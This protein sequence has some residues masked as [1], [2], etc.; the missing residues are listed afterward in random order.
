MEFPSL[1]ENVGFARN[2]A[3]VF[4]SRLDFTLDELDDIRMAVSEAVTNAVVPRLRE[5]AGH[6]P[7]H[8][9]SRRRLTGH[10]R[11]GP[12]QGDPRRGVGETARQTPLRPT[13]TWASG[14]TSSA[15]AWTGTSRTRVG[16]GTRIRMVK[17]PAQAKRQ[18]PAAS[19]SSRSMTGRRRRAPG[20]RRSR[21]G[22]STERGARWRPG[23]TGSPPGPRLSPPEHP[24]ADRPGPV[25]RPE[26]RERLIEANLRL[27]MSVAA[28]FHWARAAAGGLV[29]SGLRRPDAGGRQV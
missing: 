9:R 5:R 1:P 10:H 8:R 26:A 6:C 13:S 14:F 15:S 17:R 27:V 3:A 12:R 29:S 28:P 22:P 16:G 19:S 2:A 7:H 4:A 24:G 18:E 25:R 11:G 20:G 23:P 21:E